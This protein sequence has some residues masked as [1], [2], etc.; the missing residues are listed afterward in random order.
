[1]VRMTTEL[2]SAIDIDAPPELVWEVLTD[3]RAYPEWNPFIRSAT[4]A[5]EVGGR[6]KMTLQPVGGRR[7]TMRPTVLEA[8]PGRRLRWLGHLGVPGVF[9]GDHSFTISERN[10][11]SRLVQHE[12]FRGVLA[13][14][15]AR[16]LNRHTLPGFSAMNEAVKHRAE[17]TPE[18]RPG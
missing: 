3:L 11:G 1:M 9:D 2:S 15:M 16:S 12:T 17:R 8:A 7:I 4:G 14:L 13:P 5:I 6:L 10:G 18:T